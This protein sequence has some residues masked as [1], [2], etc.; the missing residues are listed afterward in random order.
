M[1]MS[2]EDFDCFKGVFTE[3]LKQDEENWI[4]HKKHN[5]SRARK[6]FELVYRSGLN[7]NSD[8]C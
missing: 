7:D 3:R 1:M 4:L 5:K 8:T 2:Q 6:I